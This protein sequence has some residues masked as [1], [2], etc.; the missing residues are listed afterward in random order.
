MAAISVINEATGKTVKLKDKQFLASGGEGKVFL[1]NGVIY[2]VCHDISNMI[3]KE[4]I[5]ELWALSSHGNIACPEDILVTSNKARTPIGYTSK[6]IP[7]SIPIAKLVSNGFRTKQGFGAEQTVE[8][9][10]SL[11]KMVKFVH[12]HPGILIVDLNEFNFLVNELKL[13]DPFAIDVNS[14]QTQNFPASAIMLHIIDHKTSK[15]SK[16][17]DWFSLGVVSTM[18]FL[19]DGPYGGRHPNFAARDIKARQAAT[20]SIFGPGVTLN[21]NIR[22]FDVIPDQYRSWLESMFQKGMRLPPPDV[23]G[24]MSLESIVVKLLTGSD[25]F[26][27]VKLS[28][29]TSDVIEWRSVNN[30]VICITK[31]SLIVGNESKKIRRNDLDVVVTDESRTPIAIAIKKDST[32]SGLPSGYG[33]LSLV[34]FLTNDPIGGASLAAKGFFVAGNRIYVLSVDKVIELGIREMGSK[35]VAAVN[36]EWAF[37]SLSSTV[38]S[39]L[40]YSDIFG[41]PYLTIPYAVGKCLKRH[42]PE[43]D[44]IKIT[45]AKYESGVAFVIGADQDGKYNKYIFV[46]DEKHSTHTTIEEKDIT[47]SDINFTVLD[48]GT[49]AYIDSNDA[50]VLFKKDA[51]DKRKEI[52]DPAVH[53][54]MTL[55]KRGT[56]A[57]A[58]VGKTV[59]TISMK[60]P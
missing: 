19:G 49:V 50:L 29:Y 32:T 22:S 11:V 9:V 15:F 48:N 4:K 52:R 30:T 14:W 25:L 46:F 43:L 16:L 36:K 33:L 37:Q 38:Y 17:T 10:E 6:F 28:E 60:T 58:F 7:N 18:L 13:T 45:D 3:P 20:A 26:E 41:K 8:L 24:L 40:I 39:G 51:P 54:G 57:M 34:N 12:S 44:G 23:L 59:Y 1:V 27:I 47:P 31:N 53:G 5:Q 21:K 56:Q 2:K 55:T 42:F 35:I